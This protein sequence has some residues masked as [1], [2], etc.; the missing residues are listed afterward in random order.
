MFLTVGD[1]VNT[2]MLKKV[3]SILYYDPPRSSD[4]VEL[5]NCLN[6]RDRL[7]ER[8]KEKV[9]AVLEELDSK[10]DWPD[11]KTQCFSDYADTTAWESDDEVDGYESTGLAGDP[12][13]LESGCLVRQLKRKLQY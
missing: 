6:A 5:D 10:I 11:N 1:T 13:D 12:H 2:C 7:N 8:L 4:E 3:K 9:E